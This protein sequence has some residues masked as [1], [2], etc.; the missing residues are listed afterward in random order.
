MNERRD[1]QFVSLINPKNHSDQFA[2]VLEE[3]QKRGPNE[4]QHK[5]AVKELK[6]TQRLMTIVPPVEQEEKADADPK[7][8]AGITLHADPSAS[9]LGDQALNAFRRVDLKVDAPN[10]CIW[11]ELSQHSQREYVKYRIQVYFDDLTSIN[12]QSESNTLTIEAEAYATEKISQKQA[13]DRRGEVAFE[14]TYASLE[15]IVNWN[16]KKI[17]L[18][19]KLEWSETSKKLAHRSDILDRI[20]VQSKLLTVDGTIYEKT[21]DVSIDE[22]LSVYKTSPRIYGPSLIRESGEGGFKKEDNVERVVEDKVF[23]D[24]FKQAE[25]SEFAKAEASDLSNPLIT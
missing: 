24:T 25:L 16:L 11:I 4:L 7:P 17:S 2:K 1:N 3:M 9:T 13:V 14:W 8:T 19:L 21:G 15:D 20:S 22:S 18:A 5:G 6:P 23:N 12:L 10:H